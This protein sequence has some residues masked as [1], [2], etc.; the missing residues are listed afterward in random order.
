MEIGLKFCVWAADM[1]RFDISS[2]V[3]RLIDLEVMNVLL[4]FNGFSIFTLSL[5]TPLL[6]V[7]VRMFDECSMCPG[8]SLQKVKEEFKFKFLPMSKL[9]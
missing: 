3:A 6:Y 4:I 2:A 5:L 9:A 8:C 7:V 1:A